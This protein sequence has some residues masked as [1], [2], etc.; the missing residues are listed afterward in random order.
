MSTIRSNGTV[1]HV[2]V[3]ENEMLTLP[4]SGRIAG[5]ASHFEMSHGENGGT[6]LRTFESGD[7][8]LRTAAGKKMKVAIMILPAPLEITGKWQLNFPPNWGAPENVTLDKLASWTENGDSGVKYFSG[9]AVYEKDIE[10]PADD[11][12]SSREIWLDLGAVKN[13]A[14]V[15]LNGKTFGVLWKPPFRVNI[16]GA[17]HAGSQF[18]PG[19]GNQS[20]AE[21][22]HRRRAIASRP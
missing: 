7:F 3:A 20:V 11:F 18:A 6:V 16:T 8:E 2:T 13:F 1:K 17:A 5:R 10:I 22:A 4:D 21:P 12:D 9:S 15:T 14:E 19:Q